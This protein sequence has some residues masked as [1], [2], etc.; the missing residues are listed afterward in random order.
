M[1]FD[2]PRAASARD[3]RPLPAPGPVRR[4]AAPGAADRDVPRDVLHGLLAGIAGT[5]ALDR[6]DWFFYDRE[7]QWSRRR[8]RR[9]R[10]GGEDP[11]HVLATRLERLAGMQPSPRSHEAAG[12]LI[13]YLAGTLPA[14]LYGALR[15]RA[16]GAV[17]QGLTYGLV[18]FLGDLF[19]SPASGL[20]APARAYPMRVHA[21]SLAA[22]LVYGMVTEAAI[23]ALGRRSAAA[24]ER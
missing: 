4:D 2:P 11:A 12:L 22:H 13:H 5:W 20:A 17:A 10:P 23:R 14:G 7:P 3:A 15:S 1:I 18:A 6:V 21:R 19:G 8:T 16:S 24:P 9:V